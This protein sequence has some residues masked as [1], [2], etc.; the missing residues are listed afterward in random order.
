[1]VEGGTPLSGRISVSGAK[2]AAL[3]LI[4][5][6][7]MAEGETFLENVP[8]IKDVEVMIQILNEL[9]VKS[10]WCADG[11]L[12]IISTGE[13]INVT[14]PYE[15]TKQVRASNLFLGALLGRQA[16]AA[17]SMPT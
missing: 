14:T 7:M 12:S 4:A 10:S 11:S 13:F 5:A 15:L 1:M 8:H 17:V 3:V 9:G 16:E 2:N 6:S